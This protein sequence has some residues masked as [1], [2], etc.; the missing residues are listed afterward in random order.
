MWGKIIEKI[1]SIL[2][3]NGLI[4]E[5]YDYE[6]IKFEGQPSAVVVPSD[7]TG[8]YTSNIDN[9][10]VYGLNVFLFVARGE[11]YYT[12]KECDRVMRNL[13]DSVLDDFDK[14][15]QLDG[16]ELTTG[17]SMLYMEAAP[18]AWGYADREMA[19]RMAQID[20]KIHLNVDVNQIT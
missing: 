18:S 11:N 9:E 8:D 1:K 4:Q 20:L 13:V 15:W 3:A 12:D 6:E 10:R 14:S 16:L 2:D 7:N 19:Y 5:T 17:Y